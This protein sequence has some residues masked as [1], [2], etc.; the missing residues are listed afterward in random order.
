L[1]EVSGA[2]ADVPV[3]AAPA[4]TAAASAQ[5]EDADRSK[6]GEREHVPPGRQGSSPLG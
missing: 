5:I 6:N 3:V 4:V 2:R 1:L